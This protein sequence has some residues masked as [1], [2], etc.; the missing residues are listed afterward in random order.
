MKTDIK[1][2]FFLIIGALAALYIG[3]LVI[4]RLPQ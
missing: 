3:S 4:A 2:G 1:R